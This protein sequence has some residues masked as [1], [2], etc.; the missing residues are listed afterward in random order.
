MNVLFLAPL[1]GLALLALAIPVLLHLLRRPETRVVLFPALQW[2]AQR[3]RPERRLRIQQWLLLALRLLMLA[4][5]AALLAEPVRHAPP[6]RP[7]SWWLLA[8]GVDKHALS[9]PA[10]SEARWLAPGFPSLSEPAPEKVDGFSSLLRELDSRLPAQTTLTV[11]VPEVLSGLDDEALTLRRP[12]HWQIEQG[13]ASGPVVPE[14]LTIS[15]RAPKRD[16]PQLAVLRAVA[17]AW[18][19][20]EPGRYRWDLAS[21]DKPLPLETERLIWLGNEPYPAELRRW[22]EAGGQA[23]RT[24]QGAP[25]GKPLLRDGDGALRAAREAVGA[26]QQILWRGPLDEG[27]FSSLRTADFPDRL[28]R[29]LWP[30]GV[31]VSRAYAGSVAPTVSPAALSRAAYES[32]SVA[33]ALAIALLF[34]LERCVVAW[35][36]GAEPGR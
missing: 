36:R 31:A 35:R 6:V 4:L 10:G 20:A 24:V 13:A 1:A 7:A 29:L 28:K 14:P 9:L 3:T 23:F 22:L 34:M 21:A 27:A 18:E 32:L 8:P 30:E 2:L 16:D 17:A 19:K 12:V 26:G 33:V 11:V 15:V 5:L 25:P